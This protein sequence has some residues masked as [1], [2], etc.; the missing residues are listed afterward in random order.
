MNKFTLLHTADWHLGARLCG[1]SRDDEH[2]AFLDWLV[3]VCARETPDALVIA[4]DIFDSATPPVSAQTLYYRFLHRA[5]AH[6]RH[7]VVIG[8]NHDSAAFLD[9]P[10]ALLSGMST[11]VLGASVDVQNEVMVLQGACGKAVLAMVPYLRERDIRVQ[12]AG[13]SVDDKARAVA[14]GI[15]A[16]YAQVADLAENMSDDATPRIATGHLF[17]AG[18]ITHGDDGMRDIHVGNL[19]RVGADA[20]GDV[21]DYVALGHLHRAQSVGGCDHIRYSGAPLALGFGEAGMARE[22]VRVA[23][24]ARKAQISAIAVP[25]WQKLLSLHG[26]R[27]TLAA[28]LQTLADKGESVWVEA[29]LH[30]DT[31]DSSLHDDLQA[32]LQG[33]RVKLLRLH[34][35]ARRTAALQGSDGL[36]ALE[37]LTPAQVFAA[38]L[39]RD[40]VEES[41]VRELTHAFAEILRAVEEGDAH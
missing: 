16:H 37:T 6:C 9:A 27:D 38:R 18:G 41:R 13:E 3:E 5:A 17:A 31:F 40:T 25:V 7:I 32:L 19:G 8:G 23:F 2:G 21:F 24:A 34:N 12:Q 10:R 30:A 4:G 36:P 39:A 11:H 14:A 15:A 29:H 1:Q 33:S 28:Q 35:A 26:T 22:I 20:F